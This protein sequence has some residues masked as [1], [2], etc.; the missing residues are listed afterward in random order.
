M[1]L[2][3]WR[4]LPEHR[5]ARRPRRVRKR[6]AQ[7]FDREVGILLRPPLGI[8]PSE[9]HCRTIDDVAHRRERGH[10]KGDLVLFKQSRGQTNATSLVERVSCFTVLLKNADS[11]TQS[12]MTKIVKAVMDLP[13]AGRRSITFDHGTEFVS[14]PHLQAQLGTQTSVC[15]PSSCPGRKAQSLTPT[16][17]SAA[18]FQGNVTSL[19]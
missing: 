1:A 13:L 8:L 14:W 10:W 15:D 6:R 12:V 16:G 19:P 5:M 3:L 7:R 18:G 9:I 2:E 17:G 11:R 4:Q